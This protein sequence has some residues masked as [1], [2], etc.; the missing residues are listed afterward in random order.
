[1]QLTG[2]P[3][4]WANEPGGPG[5]V[6]VMDPWPYHYSFG[7]TDAEIT[8]EN[9][10]YLDEVIMYEGPQNIAA[11]IIEPVTG[12]NGVLAPPDGYLQVSSDEARETARLLAR[13]EGVFGGFSG[14]A[15][16]AAAADLLR[17]DHKGGV[18]ACVICDSGLKYLSTDLWAD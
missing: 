9:L 13:T 3:R 8:S 6:K 14:G 16:V 10:K 18:I 17:G 2:D 7:K 12:T 5:F 11:M 4:R 1:M 15:N